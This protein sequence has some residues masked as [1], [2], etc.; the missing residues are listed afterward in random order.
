M[1]QHIVIIGAVALGPKAACRFKRL[2]PNSRVTMLDRGDIISYGGC[3]IPYFISG[4]V[5]ES[6]QLRTTSFHMV[7]DQAF[8]R[9]CKGVEA[10][11]RT[12]ALAIDRNTRQVLARDLAT[13]K[14]MVLKYDKCVIATGASPRRLEVP[15][16][17]LA[18][19]H[20]V[21][22]LHDAARIKEMVQKGQVEKAVIV[23]A[24]FIGLELAEALADMWGIE[25]TVVEIADQILPR[26]VSPGLA[27]MGQAHMQSKDVAF[28]LGETVLRFEGEERVAC[29]VTDKR[30][31]D[32]DLVIVA[33]GVTPNSELARAAGLEVSQRGAIVV[34]AQMQT[35]DPL[36]YAGGDCVEIMSQITRKPCY[37]PLGSM[38]NRQGRVIGTNLAGGAARFDGAVGAFVVKLFERSL[39]GAGLSL[40]EARQSGFDALSVLVVQYDRAHFFGNKELMTLELVVDKPTRRVLGIQGFGAA[41][42]AM[43]GRID[44]VAAILKYKP[45]VEDVSNLE[46]AYS[47][48]FAAAM[49]VINTL[50]NVADNVLAGKN[51]GLLPQEFMTLWE[52]RDDN[53]HFFI[54]CR[55]LPNAKPLLEQFPDHWHH[56]SQCRIT[57]QLDAIP[58]DKTVVLI[59]NA[60]GRSY[61][62]QTVLENQ[63]FEKVL[64]LHCGMAG[65]KFSGHDLQEQ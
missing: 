59:C 8:F 63:G 1:S 61:E 21:A 14:D 37:L 41:N 31:L 58:R 30:R 48:P 6:T 26:F 49:D 4:D 46:I 5:A 10:L 2:E 36:I 17:D 22:D 15:G 38:A 60:G 29:V 28:H 56:I 35:S 57:T 40:S 42:D 55:E 3:G 64:N 13:G 32:A 43:V 7:R 65:L 45:L 39:A 51:N 9:D 62:A 20:S 16:R 11:T 24:G 18:G 12:E 27:R 53:T 50:G 54:D 44:A 25:T 34:N 33:A 23:G 47:P 19:V 52:Q